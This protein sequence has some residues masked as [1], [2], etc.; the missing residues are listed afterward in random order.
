MRLVKSIMD[1]AQEISTHTLGEIPDDFITKRY[2]PLNKQLWNFYKKFGFELVKK[3]V[4][5]ISNEVLYDQLKDRM[6]ISINTAK[7]L[8]MERLITRINAWLG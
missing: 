6:D 8:S 7:M 4:I 5:A 3:M 1:E 2:L